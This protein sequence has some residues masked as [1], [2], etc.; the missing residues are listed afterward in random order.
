MGQGRL[1]AAGTPQTLSDS[2]DPYVRQFLRGEPDGP[3]AFQY[4][5]TPA[6][7]A[8]LAQQEGRKP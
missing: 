2:Q 5:D 4:P 1:V 8:W 6:F 3:V 7:Q